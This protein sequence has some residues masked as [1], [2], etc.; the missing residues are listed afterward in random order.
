MWPS[1]LCDVATHTV[2]VD[3]STCTDMFCMYPTEAVQQEYDNNII[4]IVVVVVTL[5]CVT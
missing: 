2:T 1:A 3:A 4:F 5:T